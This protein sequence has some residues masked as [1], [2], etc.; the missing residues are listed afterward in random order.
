MNLL[1]KALLQIGSFFHWLAGNP[2][3]NS[4]A[5]NESLETQLRAL[6]KQLDVANADRRTLRA[7]NQDLTDTNAA[8][9]DAV[10]LLKTTKIKYSE[11]PSDAQQ[12][13]AIKKLLEKANSERVVLRAKLK[14]NQD[15]NVA[16]KETIALL[17]EEVTTLKEAQEPAVL[18]SNRR[19]KK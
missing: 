4:P 17:R 2:E 19:P 9:K 13:D 10:K 3:T 14:D 16:L 11:E 1:Q 12:L 18:V 7:K 15:T 5:Q 8:L 6:K